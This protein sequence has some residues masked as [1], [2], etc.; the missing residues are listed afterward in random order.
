MPTLSE[1]VPNY[2]AS[3]FGAIGAPRNTPAEIVG[4]LNAEI[5]AA[6]R[7]SKLNA[8]LAELGATPFAGSPADLGTF[9]AAETEK[10]GKV[11]K[12]ARLKPG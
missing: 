9:I 8:R 6:L 12:S 5:N 11:V 10:W 4:K 3:V 1:F 7:D 2:E